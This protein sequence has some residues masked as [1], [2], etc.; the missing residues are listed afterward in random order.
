MYIAIKTFGYDIHNTISF[1]V[2][3]TLESHTGIYM[4]VPAKP[5]TFV[6]FT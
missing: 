5:F 2:A 4:T 6:H 1:V 3:K